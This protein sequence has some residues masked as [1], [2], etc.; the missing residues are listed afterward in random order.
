MDVI[1]TN[2][3]VLVSRASWRRV[4][5]AAAMAGLPDLYEMTCRVNGDSST[6]SSFPKHNL[7]LV[8]RNLKT[9]TALTIGSSAPGHPPTK[10]G[11]LFRFGSV[12]RLSYC[13]DAEFG[14]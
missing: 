8:P 6:L 12:S 4:A 3:D 9:L 14:N 10:A 7:E 1:D 2:S 13:G 5:A 11:P